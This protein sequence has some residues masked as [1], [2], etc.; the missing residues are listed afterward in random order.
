MP[1]SSST[2]ENVLDVLLLFNDSRPELTAG[3]ISNLIDTPR[4]T[5]Y[6]YIRTLRHKGFLERTDHDTFRPGPRLLQFTALAGTQEDVGALARP[7]M[8]ELCR[9]SQETV[10]LTRISNRH[11][12]CVER[13]ET[14]QAVRISFERGHIQP[15]HA[16]ASSKILLAYVPRDQI[17]DHLLLPLQAFTENTITDPA[18]L[19]EELCQIRRRGYCLSESEVD[20]GATAVAVPILD[21]N[22]ALVAG[23]SIAGPT[24][25]M[26]R[27]VVEQHLNRLRTAA[28]TIQEQLVRAAR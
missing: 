7:I 9:Q 8:E 5:T 17:E 11:A 13:V 18:A 3:Q 27:E 19:K 20:L 12:V 2:A 1:Q 6:R 28:T 25:R 22:Q 10:L 4:S 16:G 23:L 21:H 24:F 15:L 14:P 26:G